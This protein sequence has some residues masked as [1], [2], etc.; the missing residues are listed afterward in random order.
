MVILPFDEQLS[1]FARIL[2]TVSAEQRQALI[3]SGLFT[4]FVKADV[5]YVDLKTYQRALG[6]RNPITNASE[7]EVWFTL[8]LGPDA[9]F[10]DAKGL[11]I[12]LDEEEVSFERQSIPSFDFPA[13]NSKL[14]LALLSPRLLGF[15]D[16]YVNA[17]LVHKEALKRGF[18]YCPAVAGPLLAFAKR[19]IPEGDSICIGMK[20]RFALD[21]VY[22]TFVYSKRD[23]KRRLVGRLTG[24]F[25]TPWQYRVDQRIVFVKPR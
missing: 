1:V 2:E 5:G 11:L 14:Y 22:K 12:S 20:P 23:G 15:T 4:D 8:Y 16:E 7:T 19:D 25:N 9:C 24:I 10:R 6:L 3:N 18:E 21:D 17:E 13:E